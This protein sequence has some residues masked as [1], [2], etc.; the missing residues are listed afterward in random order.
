MLVVATLLF[1]LVCNSTAQKK[2]LDATAYDLWRNIAT[3]DI[4]ENGEWVSFRYNY[5]DATLQMKEKPLTYLRNTK[6]GTIYTLPNV[7][8][9]H[10]FDNGKYLKYTILATPNA[11]NPNAS[12]SIM[13][14]NLRT[15]KKSCWKKSSYF[16]NQPNS[17]IITYTYAISK[18]NIP[19]TRL[20]ALNIESGD[21]TVIDN[22]ENYNLFDNDRSIIYVQTQ[23]KTKSLLVGNLWGKRTVLYTD[24]LGLLGRFSLNKKATGGTFTVASD[25]L[26]K[27][28]PDLLY[29]F[30]I[31]EKKYKF[32]VDFKD[33]KLPA[34]YKILSKPYD[35][36]ENG[37]L[38]FPDVVQ[39][40][41]KQVSNRTKP[42][43]D[44]ELELW[45]WD[46]ELSQRRQR[47]NANNN[48]STNSPKFIYHIDT[49]QCVK[50]ASEASERLLVPGSS[51]YSHVIVADTKPYVPLIDWL[52]DTNFDLYLTSVLDGKTTLLGRNFHD[53]PIWSPNGKYA[54]A[55]DAEAKVWYK[56]DTKIGKLENVSDAIGYPVFDEAHDLPK[57]ASAYGLAGWTKDGN[58]VV[59]YDKYD[60]WVVDLTGNAKPYSLTKGY[61]RKNKLVFRLLDYDFDENLDITKD[62]MLKSFNEKSKAKG[63]YRLTTAGVVQKLM[64]GDFNIS[65]KKVSADGKSC[66]WTKQNYNT[67]GDLYW[68]DMNFRKPLR[69]TNANPQQEKYNWGTAKV[70]S[71]K[72]YD[73]SLNEGLLFLPENYDASK[74]YPVIVDFY[75][76]HSNDLR[77][78][79][80]PEHSEATINIVTYVSNNY[81]VFRPDVHF[82][83]GAPGESSY[84]AVVS[85][86]EELIKRGIADK[87]RIGLQGHSW[88]G[89]QVNYLVTRTNIFKCASPG[90][91]VVDM[92]SDYTTVR[93][94]GAP[95]MFM[96]ETGQCRLG[97]T[98][99]EDPQMYIK[100]SPIFNVDKI[101]TPLL[102]FHCDDDAAVTFSQGLSLF[103]AM[104]RLHKPAWLLNYKHEGHVL[105][106][107]AAQIDWE[108][109]TKQFF[110]YYLNNDPMPRWMKEGIN[111]QEKGIDQKYDDA[112]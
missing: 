4:S 89:F 112:K 5:V 25:S 82:A 10:F 41:K 1:A 34:N 58:G 3:Q 29:S 64:D 77:N 83:V 39:T 7:S 45:T 35:I 107:R 2:N 37:K 79:I 84:N 106:G 76:T 14:L 93:G 72:N 42:N 68:S 17:G 74:K 86:T 95:R 24:E 36:P 43:T 55:Y 48:A 21:S 18:N 27:A 38:L 8:D 73:G 78:Y 91:G 16:S 53:Y 98:L 92:I 26:K 99:W 94:T 49:K 31:K 11:A 32:I 96:Y 65:V 51:D 13:I 28:E 101:Q 20:V 85:G 30:S 9:L 67:F 75:E 80:A 88:S 110:G 97:K 69:I 52:Y 47:K 50:L 100:N 44:F 57:A 104:R 105:S 33:I 54:V 109:R 22:V 6:T 111:L 40:I 81:I 87:D 46:E 15:G 66:I 71:W 103:L 56:M 90:A 23:G 70:I 12:D 61:G 108:I 59:I 63:I 62:L 102:I 60:M 19:A